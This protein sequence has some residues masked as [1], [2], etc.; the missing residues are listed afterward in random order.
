MEPF[1]SN[2]KSHEHSLY[3]LDLIYHYDSFLDSINT[4]CDMGCGA[5]L[6]ALWWANLTTRDDPPEPHNYRV[7]AV[8][9]DTSR[10]DPAIKETSN[11]IVI[12]RDFEDITL[13]TRVDLVW[14]HD[15][16]QYATNPYKTLC[17]WNK[18]MNDSG[19]LVLMVPEYSGTLNN[20]IVNRCY[21]HVL[22]H[23]NIVQLIHLL[24]LAGFDC[25]DAYFYRKDGWLYA[26]VYK[27]KEPYDFRKTNLY[28]L[29]DDGMFSDSACHSIARFGYL[30]QE[31]IIYPWLDKNFYQYK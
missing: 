24:A 10:L 19:M 16:F 20:R 30:R 13:P 8:D 28:Q 1:N 21:S 22:N 11:I 29:V 4:I 31:D 27:I 18:I 3:V 14:S 26:G 2:H 15:S 23:F 7:M 25:R 9:R 6:D 5:G 12:E 17:Q